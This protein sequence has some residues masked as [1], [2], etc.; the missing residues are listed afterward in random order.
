MR[1]IDDDDR[2]CVNVGECCQVSTT[3]R[4]PLPTIHDLLLATLRIYSV[5]RS[6]HL[7]EENRRQRSL[8]VL[9]FRKLIPN[10]YVKC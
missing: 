6:L 8:A 5:R 10:L 4:V 1:Q 7:R 3:T 2:R 9:K